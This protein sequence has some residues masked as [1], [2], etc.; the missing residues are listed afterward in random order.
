MKCVLCNRIISIND[1]ED[2]NKALDEECF[3][4]DIPF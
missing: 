1:K 4:D 2:W 3:G